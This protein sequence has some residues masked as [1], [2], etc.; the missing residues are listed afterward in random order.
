MASGF[1]IPPSPYRRPQSIA[2]VP[3]RAPELPHLLLERRLS[4]SQIL[5]QVGPMTRR[6]NKRFVR[7][8]D[9]I[10]RNPHPVG[11][12]TKRRT[13]T[14]GEGAGAEGDETS[15][16]QKAPPAGGSTRTDLRIF[17]F[18]LTIANPPHAPLHGTHCLT[19]LRE[20]Q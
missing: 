15:T 6:S 7:R 20:R 4:R 18:L 11:K 2:T 5:N 12:T 8:R 3:V 14:S 17:I 9:A 13:C 19:S 10:A 1:L 16:D